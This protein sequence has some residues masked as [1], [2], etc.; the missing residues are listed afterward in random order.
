MQPSPSEGVDSGNRGILG[1]FCIMTGNV[2]SSLSTSLVG[3]TSVLLAAFV[4]IMPS[5]EH[6]WSIQ[7]LRAVPVVQ[8]IVLLEALG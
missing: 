2:M 3:C 1:L 6:N 4:V 5:S 7:L 8:S